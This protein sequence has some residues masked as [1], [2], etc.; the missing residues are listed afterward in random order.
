M[1][2]LTGALKA[3]KID[4]TTILFENSLVS[5][6]I[7]LSKFPYFSQTCILIKSYNQFILLC[8]II[9]KVN[10]NIQNKEK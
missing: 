1:F 8:L 10:D 5:T 2:L 6:P 9:G 3:L 4:V 7:R